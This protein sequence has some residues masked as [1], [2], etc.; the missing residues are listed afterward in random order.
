MVM[1]ES[2]GSSL[3]FYNHACIVIVIIIAVIVIVIFISQLLFKI[4]FY[5]F[6]WE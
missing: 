4:R 2:L 5:D 3:L 1:I 6:N